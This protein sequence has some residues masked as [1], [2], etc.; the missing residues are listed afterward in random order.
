MKDTGRFIEV[1]HINVSNKAREAGFTHRVE[2]PVQNIAKFY[3][4]LNMNNYKV[5]NSNVDG[6]WYW[7]RLCAA[8]GGLLATPYDPGM[9]QILYN[10]IQ[11]SDPALAIGQVLRAH[12]DENGVPDDDPSKTFYV[13]VSGKIG[14]GNTPSNPEPCEDYKQTS[15]TYSPLWSTIL[16]FKDGGS[17]W[18]N[19]K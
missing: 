18:L 8:E 9:A 6:K 17:G 4:V 5:E 2:Y 12:F 3:K 14:Y 15:F 11:T 7:H 19:L 10:S 16:G 13:H 1:P